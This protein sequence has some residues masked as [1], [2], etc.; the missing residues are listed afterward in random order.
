MVH[1]ASEFRGSQAVG[2]APRHFAFEIAAGMQA[3]EMCKDFAAARHRIDGFCTGDERA[4]DECAVGLVQAEHGERTRA[5]PL[6]DG[7]DRVGVQGSAHRRG[8]TACSL[9]TRLRA[10]MSGA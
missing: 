7:V 5:T 10:L 1:V 6:D 9:K 3:R 4:N 2:H 8:L